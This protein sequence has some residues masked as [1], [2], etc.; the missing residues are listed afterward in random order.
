MTSRYSRLD[1]RKECR[2]RQLAGKIDFGLSC[3]RGV[4]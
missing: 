3:G 4:R 1:A 2:R